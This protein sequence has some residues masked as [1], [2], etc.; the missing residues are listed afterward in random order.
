MWLGKKTF[1]R[2]Q[3]RAW[4]PSP[5]ESFKVDCFLIVIYM[6]ITSVKNIFEYLK[7]SKNIFEFLYDLQ[8]ICCVKF[9]STFSHENIW[10]VDVDDLFSKLRLLQFTFPNKT[11]S[12]ID[13]IK[14]IKL[15]D[16]YPNVS[17][18]YRILGTCSWLVSTERNFL[19]LKLIKIYL[20]LL[21]ICHKRD[22]TVWM[23]L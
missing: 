23:W 6:I 16:C 1:W 7:T 14:F 20:R 2:E 11:M 15:A 13:I 8:N 17:I 10:D 19:K 21:L 18:V 4:N 3:R 12:A 5:E 9:H 22:W